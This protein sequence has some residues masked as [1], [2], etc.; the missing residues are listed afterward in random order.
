MKYVWLLFALFYAW[1]LGIGCAVNDM[2]PGSGRHADS[3]NMWF[4]LACLV[5]C[6]LFLFGHLKR[7]TEEPSVEAPKQ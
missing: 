2:I 5:L 6:L 4:H 1:L 7:K 3:F